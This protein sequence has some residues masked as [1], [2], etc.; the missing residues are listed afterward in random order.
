MW[1]R[2]GALTSARA[3]AEDVWLL[4]SRR[5]RSSASRRGRADPGQ[6]NLP[7]GGIGAEAVVFCPA[8]NLVDG[9]ADSRELGF[10]RLPRPVQ[11]LDASAMEHAACVD[12]EIGRVGDAPLP[13]AIRVFGRLELVVGAS[14][15]RAAAQAR[16]RACLQASSD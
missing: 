16:D 15:D 10:Q 6:R 13:Q 14:R 2:S 11:F 9:V 7:R 3:N 8:Q 12:D 1:A 4:A 5:T